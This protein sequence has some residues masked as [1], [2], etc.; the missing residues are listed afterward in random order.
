M[1][2]SVLE[3]FI[4][5]EETTRSKVDLPFST[6]RYNRANRLSVFYEDDARRY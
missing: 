2:A 4:S 3:F 5:R 6:R 1:Y